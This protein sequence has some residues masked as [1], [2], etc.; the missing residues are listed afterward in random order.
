MLRNDEMHP[1]TYVSIW[2]PLERRCL[3]SHADLDPTFGYDGVV[4]VD[5]GRY[6]GFEDM[7]VQ[8]DGKIVAA[9]RI[10]SP[11]GR[12]SDALLVR[13]NADGSFDT[14]F[15]DGGV[16]RLDRGG[17]ESFLDVELRY[18]SPGIIAGGNVTSSR[19]ML[20]S[21]N[22]N[23]S[24]YTSFG[25]GDGVATVDGQFS[26]LAVQS[27][28]ILSATTSNLLRRHTDHGTLDT[29]FGAGGVVDMNEV[30]RRSG[31][32][33]AFVD[34]TSLAVQAKGGILVGTQ[35][36]FSGHEE[37]LDAPV[38]FRLTPGGNRDW[39]ESLWN[40]EGGVPHV[41]QQ[42]GGRI[43]AVAGWENDDFES[44]H[45]LHPDGTTDET[46]GEL[47]DDYFRG[48]EAGGDA[49]V[50]VLPDGKILL[51]DR[52]ASVRRLLPNGTADE[53]FSGGD[54]VE[55]EFIPGEL[56]LA[57]A[58]ATAPD[59]GVFL[60]GN[61]GLRLPQR[62]D[63]AENVRRA[64]AI[65]KILPN[66][67][68]DM[69][70]HVR[71]AGGKLRIDGTDQSD[72][73]NVSSDG[74]VVRVEMN[75]EFMTFD[76]VAVQ[77]LSASLGDGDDR[78]SI[79][80]NF[81]RR[82]TVNGDAGSDSLYG[83]NRDDL[84]TGGDGYNWIFGRRGNDSLIGGG[85]VDL[86]RGDHGDD[87]IDG[88][89]TSD[90]LYGGPGRDT[91]TGGDGNDVLLGEDGDDTISG[92]DGRDAIMGD[93]GNDVLLGEGGDDPLFGGDGDDLMI[94]GLGND[95]LRGETGND[96]L[97]GNDGND[98]LFGH[99]GNDNMNGGNG[100]DWLDGGSGIDTF[101]GHAGNDRLFA[102]DGNAE[103]VN[104]GPGTDSAEADD[105]LDALL[106]IESV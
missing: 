30:A 63:F 47:G 41:A 55:V 100:A 18:G 1:L 36:F 12:T 27:F 6:G 105:E 33:E 94:G 76:L 50:A 72:D 80:S 86:I 58:V 82:T 4:G 2:E 98:R 102:R 49:G 91:I 71:L 104:G 28:S 77:R 61:S 51:A 35:T 106:R 60:A 66:P 101:N 13:F 5:L 29:G 83:G 14:S 70:S 7:V 89:G 99:D 43:L 103:V 59:G 16:V 64:G 84:L 57:V 46:F 53:R 8:S 73:I 44:L 87:F 40:D 39:D 26:A 65:A 32:Y 20:A 85:Y 97:G 93:A 19:Y 31:Y 10:T 34:I 3:L 56:S 9:G 24:P 23:G 37:A 54:A 45:A 48:V 92:G 68:A 38:V 42:A 11:S 69:A 21:F 22:D 15:G 62:D 88:A 96:V 90:E 52:P 95:T 81:P 75:G 79:A 25:G 74:T 17:N 67:V 78:F